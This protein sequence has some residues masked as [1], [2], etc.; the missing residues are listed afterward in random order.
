M[1][2][3]GRHLLVVVVL[4]QRGLGHRTHLSWAGRCMRQNLGTPLCCSF[5]RRD[6]GVSYTGSRFPKASFHPRR[7]LPVEASRGPSFTTTHSTTGSE[8]LLQRLLDASG[9]E[10]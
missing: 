3:H 6:P 1:F 9:L 10:E 8:C 4:L 2:H 7:P 5:K